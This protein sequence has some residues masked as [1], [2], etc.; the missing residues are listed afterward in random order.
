M[1]NQKDVK[2][3][4]KDIIELSLLN[5]NIDYPNDFISALRKFYIASLNLGFLEIENLEKSVEDFTSKISN[6]VFCDSIEKLKIF[7]DDKIR[8]INYIKDGYIID[9]GNLVLNEKLLFFEDDEPIDMLTGSCIIYKAIA[10]IIFNAPDDLN[11]F[12]DVITEIAAEKIENMDVNN[13]RIIMPHSSELTINNQIITLRAGYTRYNLLINLTKQMFIAL[14]I[15]ENVVI[16]DMMNEDYNSV[17]QKLNQS[18]FKECLGLL[19]N[20]YKAYLKTNIFNCEIDDYLELINNYQ[21]KVNDLFTHIDHN[22]FVFCAL[23][24]SDSLR[25]KLMQKFK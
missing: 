8:I 3:P 6:I 4:I 24:T 9:N 18:D 13:S 21:V 23:V 1:S 16:R 11:T 14:Q 25:E 7:T 15:N 10:Q 2:V 17:F 22:Y 12:A 20:V 19:N 5:H